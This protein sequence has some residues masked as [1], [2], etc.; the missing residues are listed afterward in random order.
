M[1]NPCRQDCKGRSADCHSMC[2][3]YRAYYEYNRQKNEQRQQRQQAEAALCEMSNKRAARM[4]RH[5]KRDIKLE[6]WGT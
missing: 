3:K 5:M 6:K 2:G 1:K 4:Q